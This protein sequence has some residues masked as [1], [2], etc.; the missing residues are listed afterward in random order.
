MD[1]TPDFVFC[2][3][4][5]G[6]RYIWT[7]ADLLGYE[8]ANT[9]QMRGHGRLIAPKYDCKEEM[10]ELSQRISARQAPRANVRR[11]AYPK[12]FMLLRAFRV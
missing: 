7:A 10:S 9:R 2:K 8:Y 12:Y 5:N 11:V 3:T 1:A 4:Q 6:Q